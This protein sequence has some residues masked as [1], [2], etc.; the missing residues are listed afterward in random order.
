MDTDGGTS[1]EIKYVQFID[2]P[3]DGE[4]WIDDSD[5]GPFLQK[6]GWKPKH[7]R[8]R[9]VYEL[10]EFDKEFFYYFYKGAQVRDQKMRWSYASQ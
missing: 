6:V 4:I 1:S 9:H 8:T 10:I 7:G 5:L 2:G 3:K